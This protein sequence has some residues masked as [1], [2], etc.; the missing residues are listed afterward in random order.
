MKAF[1]VELN[2]KEIDQVSNSN[3]ALR[4]LAHITAWIKAC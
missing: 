1:R 3:H 4:L 2:W